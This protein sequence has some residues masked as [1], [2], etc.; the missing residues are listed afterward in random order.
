M[1]INSKTHLIGMLN[2]ANYGLSSNDPF[3]CNRIV[4]TKICASTKANYK[5]LNYDKTILSRLDTLHDK[6]RSVVFSHPENQL[7]SFSPPKSIEY[8]E[9]KEK[10]YPI[11]TI[12]ATE[13]IEGVSITLFYD[14][15]IQSWE[16]STKTNVGGHYWYFYRPLHGTT[17]TTFYDMFMDALV[18]PRYT[19]LKNIALFEYLP[20]NY[21]YCFVLQHPDNIITIP[22]KSPKLWLV[23]IYEI[24]ENN[25]IQ[26]PS[27]VYKQ[28]SYLK[29]ITGIIHFPET[30]DCSCYGE[31]EQYVAKYRETPFFFSEGIVLWNEKTGVRTLL[32][33][34]NYIDLGILQ[35]M[36][37][38]VQY[39]YFCMKRIAKLSEYKEYFPQNKKTVCAMENLY[40]DFVYTIHKCYMDVYVYKT[41]H[42]NDIN[43]QYQPYIEDL[44]KTIY[45]PSIKTRNPTKITRK[46]VKQYVDKMDPASQLFMFSY[47]RREL[48]NYV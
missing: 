4:S 40:R 31:L 17:R 34:Q 48:D 29:N 43:M 25:A 20:K 28:W 35:K 15:R 36:I 27:D 5:I 7:L 14:F 26:I 21:C 33:N 9:F 24:R 42:L 10:K 2:Y 32:K 22:V 44:H 19:Q 23:A 46:I 1:S 39:E 45:L 13:K 47:L 30:I 6:Y 16:I 3:M 37:P 8:T 11:N 18:Q 41:I 12:T 38:S